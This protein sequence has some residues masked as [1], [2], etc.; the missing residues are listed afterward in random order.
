M[1]WLALA[2][3]LSAPVTAQITGRVVN[4]TN[5]EA[6]VGARVR[7][8][9]S[10]IFTTT[11]VNGQF[12]LTDSAQTPFALTAA[13]HGFYNGRIDIF[14]GPGD[15]ILELEEV[16][17]EVEP[18][19]PLNV[20][21][22]CAGCHP[23]VVAQWTGSPMQETGL[24]SWVFDLYDGSATSGGSNGFVYQRDSIHRLSSPN[25]DCSACHS[26]VHWL[27][28]IENN[29]MGDYHNSNSDME[30]GVQC[31]ICHR[32]YDVDINQ[33]Y[34]PGVQPRSFTLLRNDEPLEFGV[35]GDAYFTQSIMKPAYNPQLKAQTCSACHQDNVDH[36]GDGEFDDPGSLPHETTFSEWQAWQGLDAN[37]TQT[38]VDCHMPVLSTDSFCIF[39]KGRAPGTVRSHAIRG[40]TPAYLENALS[41]EAQVSANLGEL[42]VEVTL[43]NNLTGHAVPSGVVVRNVI[44]LVIARNQD[45]QRLQHQAGDLVDVVG[46][47]GDFEM[48]D[49]AGHPGKAFYLNMS[50]GTNEQVF[51][52]EAQLIASDTRLQP[53]SVYGGQ[54]RFKLD[55]SQRAHVDVKVL[56][57]RAYR[58]IVLEKGWTETGHGE[59]LADI[60]AP[61]YGHLMERHEQEIEVCATKDLD[62]NGTIDLGD[63][64]LLTTLWGEPAPFGASS[65]AITNLRHFVALTNCIQ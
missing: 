49:Y 33:T 38:C 31:E 45:D 48:G 15:H 8:H 18:N 52:T 19:A 57:R 7:I 62:G 1:F 41:L 13:A 55:R 22:S 61:D 43:S 53:G 34:E 65:A 42:I 4:R 58:S 51:Y 46:G 35:L 54:F 21:Q 26:P 17:L 6:I 14:T 44:L 25:S 9:L 37:N 16:S 32:A 36:D 64:G 5:Q 30:R 2:N 10:T 39:V 56:Y 24:N 60:Q 11:D 20:P 12:S 28:D 3:C 50:D 23:E 40:T 27:A 29:G 47:V 63:L 59:A